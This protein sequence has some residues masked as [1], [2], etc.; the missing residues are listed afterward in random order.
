[1]KLFTDL[2]VDLGIE[3]IR[4]V[5]SSNDILID[6]P[7]LVA[8]NKDKEIVAIGKMAIS[9]DGKSPY[10]KVVSPIGNG[11]ITDIGIAE[12]VIKYFLKKATPKYRL[13]KPR[14][15]VAAYNGVSGHPCRLSSDSLRR[16]IFCNSILA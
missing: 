6:E 14:V 16:D 7:S 8:I 10:V 3:N 1:M 13:L 4:I 9:L 2:A 11:I 15:I 12:V 5:S